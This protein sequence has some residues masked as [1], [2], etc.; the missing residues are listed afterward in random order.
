M[1]SISAIGLLFGALNKTSWF[2]RTVQSEINLK[3]NKRED[4][5]EINVLERERHLTSFR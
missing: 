1:R 5:K 2:E 3:R 4:K